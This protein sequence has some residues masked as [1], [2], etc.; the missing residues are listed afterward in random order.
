MWTA[1]NTY[2][3]EIWIQD[4]LPVAAIGNAIVND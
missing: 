3:M 4:I 1:S 2:D